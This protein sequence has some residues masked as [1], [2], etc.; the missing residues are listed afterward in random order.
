MCH[1]WHSLN[2][3][4]FA[5][6]EVSVTHPRTLVLL[7]VSFHIHSHTHRQPNASVDCWSIRYDIRV[8]SVCGRPVRNA[9]SL[10]KI[11]SCDLLTVG[12]FVLAEATGSGGNGVGLKFFPFLADCLHFALHCQYCTCYVSS[13]RLQFPVKRR[14]PHLHRETWFAVHPF[15]LHLEFSHMTHTLPF[16]MIRSF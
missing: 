6:G 14:E 1:I 7:L 5:A 10:T 15:L 12:W 16:L 3:T 9:A 11:R 8:V 13:N 4:I 2:V